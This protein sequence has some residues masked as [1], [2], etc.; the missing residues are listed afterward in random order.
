LEEKKLL[1]GSDKKNQ[2]LSFKN[3]QIF[4]YYQEINNLIGEQSNS[5]QK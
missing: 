4:L 3:N 2:K 1:K 5:G